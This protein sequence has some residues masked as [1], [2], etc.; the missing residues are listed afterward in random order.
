M[1]AGSGDFAP[2]ENVYKDSGVRLP[3]PTGTFDAC[4]KCGEPVDGM[5]VVAPLAGMAWHEGCSP[6]RQ[7]T[8]A[9]RASLDEALGG[10]D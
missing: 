6:A 8:E 5:A 1:T 10:A 7:A 9:L 3:V 4:A 2:V